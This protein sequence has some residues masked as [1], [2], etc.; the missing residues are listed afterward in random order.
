MYSNSILILHCTMLCCIV[1]RPAVPLLVT[2]GFL[3][4]SAQ[5]EILTEQFSIIFLRYSQVQLVKASV[6][7]RHSSFNL[8]QLSSLTRPASGRALKALLRQAEAR[9]PCL[10]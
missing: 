10:A 6:A 3:V 9:C 4:D 7:G 1:L 5:S 8:E 2:S